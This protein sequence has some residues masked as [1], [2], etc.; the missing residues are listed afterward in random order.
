AS[1]VTKERRSAGRG[2]LRN[3][4]LKSMRLRS[5]VAMA[6]TSMLS[7]HAFGQTS[8]RLDANLDGVIDF[9]D[10][11]A[12]VQTGEF[13]LLNAI[14]ANW[15]VRTIIPGQGGPPL[16][17]PTGGEANGKKPIARWAEPPFQTASGAFRLRGVAADATGILAVSF[18]ANES[19]SVFVTEP[20]WSASSGGYEYVALIEAA[21]L[22]VNER[23]EV[24][25]IVY[26]NSGS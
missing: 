23:V 6:A 2:G 9:R 25:A 13:S 14:M 21:D 20:V 1:C 5:L 16:P 24:S 8:L 3:N 19:S 15:G 26:P 17:P 7:L 12:A 4:R 22:G 18:S 10:F 11:N